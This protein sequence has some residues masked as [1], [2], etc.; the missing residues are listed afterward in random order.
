LPNPWWLGAVRLTG[1]LAGLLALG[2]AAIAIESELDEAHAIAELQQGGH[3]V[4]LRHAARFGGPRD[5][6]DRW[7]SAAQFADCRSQRNLTPQGQEQ[8]RE[9]G[10]YWRALRI[11]VQ[12]VIAS[13]QCRTRDT[14]ILAFGTTAVDPRLFDVN[15][16]RQLTQEPVPPGTNTVIVGSDFQLRYLTGID[17]DYA[18][19]ALLKP[20][21]K[22]GITVV[23]RLDLDDWADAAEPGWW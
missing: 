7:S 14:A 17:L 16:V 22:G 15:F 11:P 12:R 5:K 2:C 9:I 10:A 23:A 21:G 8:A 19:A 18:E 20:D 1:G 13:A 4:Y 3:V 6:L